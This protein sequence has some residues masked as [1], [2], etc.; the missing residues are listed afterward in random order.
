MPDLEVLAF[1]IYGTGSAFDDL[2]LGAG[3]HGKVGYGL[4]RKEK[5]KLGECEAKADWSKRHSAR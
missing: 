3:S 4:K 1:K 5:R 2:Y